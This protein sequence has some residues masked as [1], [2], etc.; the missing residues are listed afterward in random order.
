MNKR[1][2]SATLLAIMVMLFFSIIISGLIPM[3]NQE[4]KAITTDHNVLQARYAAEAGIKHA[5]LSLQAS[6]TIDGNTFYQSLSMGQVNNKAAQYSL[7]ITPQNG[8]TQLAA[9]TAL[10]PGT[11]YAIT[12]TGTYNGVSQTVTEYYTA[13]GGGSGDAD[14][15]WTPPAT[16]DYA[17]TIKY[18]ALS[19]GALTAWSG[20][21]V[22]NNK[23]GANY[24][25]A[26]TKKIDPKSYRVQIPAIDQVK[27]VDLK[28]LEATF[29][30]PT[31]TLFSA[32]T[33]KTMDS[34]MNP[35]L[36]YSS[37]WGDL[38]TN[39][40]IIFPSGYS[41]Y[42]VSG[43]VV[44]NTPLTLANG[45]R[46]I[47][48][49]S[50]DIIINSPLSGH[51]ALIAEGDIQLDAA[52][53]GH[54]EFYSKKDMRIYRSVTGYGLFMSLQNLHVTAGTYDKA[55]MFGDNSVVLSGAQVTGA[56]YSRG[57]MTLEGAT[58]ITYD[59]NAIPTS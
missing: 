23:Y 33:R 58:N 39:S 1:N 26:T 59:A 25:L 40:R 3:M 19:D 6:N 48:Y 16:T 57:T 17:N 36:Q 30:K 42:E 34:V 7:S 35:D 22:A 49:S 15:I 47:I 24:A 50:K 14:V 9:N 2:G 53:T 44:V 29:F 45:S 37:S 8:T 55:F 31:N 46:V 20:N 54:I 56:V 21:A 4:L 28:L 38:W 18:A 10:T 43:K 12:S 13:S 11:I 51:F 32:Y 41:F 5:Y 52:C 27:N